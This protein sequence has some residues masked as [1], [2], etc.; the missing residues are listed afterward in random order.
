MGSDYLAMC[1]NPEGQIDVGNTFTTFDF[2]ERSIYIDTEISQSITAIVFETIRFWNKIDNINGTEIEERKPIRIFINSPGG[3]LDATLSIVA[4]IESSL[5]PVY[6]YNIG[7][8]Y[9]GAL[10]ILVSGHKRFALPYASYMFHEGA[11]LFSGDAHKIVQQGEFYKIQLNQ[12]KNIILKNTS[13]SK[14]EYGKH[15]KDDWWFANDTAISKS[16]IDK[17]IDFIGEEDL[18]DVE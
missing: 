13:I 17:V 1:T 11:A 14:D 5:T 6:T 2:I 4:T 18:E 10:F 8:A 16:I 12:V 7:R 3:D 15:R 9:S